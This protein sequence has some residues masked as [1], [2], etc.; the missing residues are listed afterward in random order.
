ME[1]RNNSNVFFWYRHVFPCHVV[2]GKNSIKI[3]NGHFF[4]VSSTAIVISPLRLALAG[5]LCCLLRHILGAS[6]TVMSRATFPSKWP[7]FMA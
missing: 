3:C 7:N 5:L 4:D 1:T 6:T 2:R